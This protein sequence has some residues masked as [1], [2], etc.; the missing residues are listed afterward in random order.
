MRGTWFCNYPSGICKW[1]KHLSCFCVARVSMH[2]N[3]YKHTMYCSTPHMRDY[4]FYH[5]SL[6]ISFL[7]DCIGTFCYRFPW[8]CYQRVICMLLLGLASCLSAS[9]HSQPSHCH[10][11][12]KSWRTEAFYIYVCVWLCVC[13]HRSQRYW[14][15]WALLSDSSGGLR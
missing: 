3:R 6:L 5:L 1:R 7:H 13:L 15:C 12:N 8:W 10:Q 2:R 9:Q 11:F 4:L 14:R